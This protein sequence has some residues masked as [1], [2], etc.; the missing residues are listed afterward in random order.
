MML[1]DTMIDA[2]SD[3]P[4]ETLICTVQLPTRIRNALAMTEIK[5]IG[6]ISK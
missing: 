2:A 6:D 5:T 4:D 1:R 3:L